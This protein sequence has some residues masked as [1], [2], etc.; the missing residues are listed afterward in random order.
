[1]LGAVSRDRRNARLCR[2]SLETSNLSESGEGGHGVLA[3]TPSL[4]RR[5]PEYETA[6]VGHLH[7]YYEIIRDFITELHYPFIKRVYQTF[8]KLASKRCVTPVRLSERP[9]DRS[10]E[11]RTETGEQNEVGEKTEPQQQESKFLDL[12]L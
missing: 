8:E 12:L 7:A 1:M 5:T 3:S 9:S 11:R 10:P 6:K 4:L 2:V